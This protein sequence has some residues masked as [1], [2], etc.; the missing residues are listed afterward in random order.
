MLLQAHH[1]RRLTPTLRP[2]QVSSSQ[3]ADLQAFRLYWQSQL[4]P[5][6]D[7]QLF[8][9]AGGHSPLLIFCRIANKSINQTPK[10]AR[11]HLDRSSDVPRTITMA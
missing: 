6:P 4:L 2:V 3:L 5:M 8:A 7:F 10:G 11:A 9:N 1:I